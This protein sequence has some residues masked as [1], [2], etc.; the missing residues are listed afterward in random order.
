MLLQSTSRVSNQTRTHFTEQRHLETDLSGSDTHGHARK[1]SGRR[2]R[3]RAASIW[4]RNAFKGL[5]MGKFVGVHDDD[6]V[7]AIHDVS[8]ALKCRKSYTFRPV[9]L[10]RDMLLS[11][12][13]RV[14]VSWVGLD[15]TGFGRPRLRNKRVKALS[16]SRAGGISRLRQ[17]PR[18]IG[19]VHD[20]YST[21]PLVRWREGSC[22]V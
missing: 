15:E 21:G 11:Q 4:L 14:V 19:D 7:G 10:S 20:A 13:H 12:V 5:N 6:L 17:K 2:C 22:G 18:S 9:G 8:P 16:G 1:G 3:V